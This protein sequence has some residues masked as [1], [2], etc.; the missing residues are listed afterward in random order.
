L[1]LPRVELLLFSSSILNIC[2]TEDTISSKVSESTIMNKKLNNQLY[3][4]LKP[5]LASA[6]KLW[7]K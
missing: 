6:G 7:N 5:Y 1:I 3:L 2:L 4:T